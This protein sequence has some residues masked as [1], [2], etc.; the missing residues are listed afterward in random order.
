MYG[1]RKSSS[2]RNNSTCTRH[3]QIFLKRIQIPLY[4][5]VFNVVLILVETVYIYVY[6]FNSFKTV[7]VWCVLS[8]CH[9][10]QK[11]I[12]YLQKNT[13]IFYLNS[14]YDNILILIRPKPI[15]IQLIQLW[16]SVLYSFHLI[17]NIFK[18]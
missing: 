17:I 18:F 15:R 8:T 9:F 6:T 2:P 1:H 11:R 16:Y 3:K 12:F 13:Y 14:I 10:V 4:Y 7:H 5:F